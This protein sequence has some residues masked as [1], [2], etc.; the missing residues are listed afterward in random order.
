MEHMTMDIRLR[1]AMVLQR[2]TDS[3][4]S[5]AEV[6]VLCRDALAEIERQERCVAQARR[7]IDRSLAE[8]AGVGK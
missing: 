2:H 7:L 1:L 4:Y 5:V 8:L 6:E 3:A